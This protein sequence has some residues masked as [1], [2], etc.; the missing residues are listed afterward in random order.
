MH[1]VI[2]IVLYL[3]HETRWTEPLS[4]KKCLDIPSD[5]ETYVHDYKVNLFEIGW[6]TM[7]EV[8]R[9]FCGDFRIVAEFFV[10]K[11][12]NTDYQPRP[13][14]MQH[15]RE[16][17]QLISAMAG[18][19]R[20]ENAYNQMMSENPSGQKGVTMCSVYDQIENKGIEKGI[21]KGRQEGYRSAQT[22]NARS[23]RAEGLSLEQIARILHL[24]VT[25]VL[26]MLQQA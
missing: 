10:Q 21:E 19:H 12:L 26:G 18:D 25:D 23:M 11:R 1:P 8:D 7:E 6:M 15:A 24:D 14:I 2:S 9:R 17:I 13:Q 20:Y 3:N 4:L 16:V 22:D 5:I